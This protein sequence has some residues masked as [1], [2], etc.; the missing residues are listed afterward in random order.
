[1][2][3][4]GIAG[5]GINVVILDDGLDFNSTDLADNFVRKKKKRGVMKVELL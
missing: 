5:K 3:K 4:Q 1:M 2:W